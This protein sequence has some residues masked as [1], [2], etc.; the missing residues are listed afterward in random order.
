MSVRRRQRVERPAADVKRPS[1]A[2][3][4]QPDAET[5]HLCSAPHQS[6]ADAQPTAASRRNYT[7]AADDGDDEG[8]AGRRDDSDDDPADDADDEDGDGDGGGRPTTTQ[9]RAVGHRQVAS[10]RFQSRYA[11]Q[12]SACSERVAWE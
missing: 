11:V 1:E 6:S 3:H 8:N 2:F 9:S 10:G 12:L 5:A 4:Q 7:S